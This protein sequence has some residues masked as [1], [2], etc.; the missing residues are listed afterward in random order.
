[1][2]DFALGM[3]AVLLFLILL[4]LMGISKRLKGIFPTDKEIERK[5]DRDSK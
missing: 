4:E 1:M 5:W 2:T 3:I